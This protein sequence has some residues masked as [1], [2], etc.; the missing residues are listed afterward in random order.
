MQT[1]H[2]SRWEVGLSL[3]ASCFST[4]LTLVTGNPTQGRYAGANGL[5]GVR[6]FTPCPKTKTV[7]SLAS[8]L[9]LF[10][11]ADC[12]LA[13]C[14]VFEDPVRVRMTSARWYPSSVRLSDGSLLILG[15]SECFRYRASQLHFL[16][17]FLLPQ[18]LPYVVVDCLVNL[19]LTL[20]AGW[21]QQRQLCLLPTDRTELTACST[22]RHRRPTILPSSE[23]CRLSRLS[24]ELTRLFRFYPPKGD[25]LQFYSKVGVSLWHSQ[26]CEC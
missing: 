20:V 24:L 14:D 21:L 22:F 5:Q 15:G 12:F 1:E 13:Q 19:L 3:L 7:S 2:S 25:G 26:L 6:L 16:T 18:W 10:D 17:M 8:F 9:P 23:W 4:D 11:F